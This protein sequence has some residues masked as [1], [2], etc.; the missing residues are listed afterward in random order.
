MRLWHCVIGKRTTSSSGRFSPCPLA[1]PTVVQDCRPCNFVE[2]AKVFVGCDPVLGQKRKSPHEEG[3]SRIWRREWDSN[4]RTPV[5]MLLEFQSSAFDH[6]AISPHKLNH[7]APRLRSLALWTGIRNSSAARYSVHPWT[8]PLRANR[9]ASQLGCSN[10]LPANL[11]DHSAISPHKLN[12]RAPRLRS[13][14]IHRIVDGNPEFRPSALGPRRLQRPPGS[15]KPD[16]GCLQ[17]L[18]DVA[19]KF[20]AQGGEGEAD[21]FPDQAHPGQRPLHGDRIGLEE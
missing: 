8:S 12:H 4:P 18:K 9:S 10:S 11:V 16:P 1:H 7:R 3:F 19:V 17:C 15:G 13:I 20:L 5:K 14:V 6:S 21:A 2:H